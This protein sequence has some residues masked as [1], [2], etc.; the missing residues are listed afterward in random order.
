MVRFAFLLFVFLILFLRLVGVVVS[1]IV[2]KRRALD[3]MEESVEKLLEDETRASI[4]SLSLSSPASLLKKQLS[5]EEIL[6][7]ILLPVFAFLL[8][9]LFFSHFLGGGS[10]SSFESPETEEL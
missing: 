8:A 2:S 3:S 9:R 7:R 1:R 6:I 10:T 4:S 5:A